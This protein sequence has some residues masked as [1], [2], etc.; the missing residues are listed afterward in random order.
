[1][2]SVKPTGRVVI[3]SRIVTTLAA[4][5]QDIRVTDVR[6]GLGCTAV[7]LMANRLGV[8]YTFPE[9]ARRGKQRMFYESPLREV[10]CAGL[11]YISAR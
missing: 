11:V 2:Q 8:T 7:K 3:A 6:I 4:P 9:K 5:A 10:G 1:M